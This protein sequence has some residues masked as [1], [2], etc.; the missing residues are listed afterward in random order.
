MKSILKFLRFIR[1]GI[2]QWR[3][4]IHQNSLLHQIQGGI[5]LR[6]DGFCKV[7]HPE[8]LQLGSYVYIGGN[9]YINCK[10]N[11]SIGDYTI[12]SRNVTIYSYD[13]HFKNPD[14]LPYDKKLILKPVRIGNY[15]WIGMNVTVA[16][17]TVIGNG[18]V[19]GAGA[20]VSGKI[21]ENAIVVSAKPRIIGYR[22][23]ENIN[24]LLDGGKFFNKYY[25]NH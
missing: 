7:I 5:S 17:G 3:L 18:A 12:L 8:N 13:H 1:I 25:L 22:N 11:V 2:Y 19:I 21:P 16:P 10:G 6:L 15:V 4:K 20:V 9:A 14:M 23:A 24:A